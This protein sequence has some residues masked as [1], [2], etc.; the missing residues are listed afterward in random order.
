ML[1][2]EFHGKGKMV[3]PRSHDNG[4]LVAVQCPGFILKLQSKVSS[5]AT[6]QP[7]VNCA[8]GLQGGSCI[9]SGG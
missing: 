6:L 4:C 7:C 5:M 3:G 8:L 2:E 1:V 9:H